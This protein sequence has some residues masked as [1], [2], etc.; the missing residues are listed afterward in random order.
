MSNYFSNLWNAVRGVNVTIDTEEHYE[1]Y[2]LPLILKGGNFDLNNAEKIST[3][4]TCISI[5]ANSVAR[6]PINVIKPQSDGSR[7]PD[8]TDYR[9]PLLHWQPNPY[10]SIHKML[11]TWEWHCNTNG[12]AFGKIWRDGAGRAVKVT[13]IPPSTFIGVKEV[14]GNLYYTFKEANGEKAY[15]AENI[16]HFYN[17]TKDGM[18][19]V[20]PLTAIRLNMTSSWQAYNTINNMYQNE[21]RA[22]KA[23]KWP[24]F[25][26]NKKAQQEA[27]KQFKQEYNGAQAPGI[28]TI[29]DGADLVDLQITP[30]DA[31]FI[32][33]IKFNKT[34]IA[35]AFRVPLTNVGVL[36]AAKFNSV[37]MMAQEFIQLG[38]GDRLKMY[39][40]ELEMKL[41]SMEE[42]MNG[43]SIEFNTN[44]LLQLD[45]KTRIDGYTRLIQNGQMTPNYAN[46]LENLPTYPEGD[47]HFMASNFVFVEDRGKV[48]GADGG[49]TVNKSQGI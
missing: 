48:Q 17:V 22:S 43:T 19:G 5:L 39:R 49:N 23:L 10:T 9:Y 4:Y 44:A 2:T 35:S 38:L 6:C 33:T 1:S 24:Q 29:P 26:P 25:M 37:E 28:V 18:T 7:L 36:E 12:N 13:L 40:T 16:L 21:L 31:Q 20:S 47:K 34:D 30:E 15:N 8:K 41:L 42:K 46:I 27:L 45:Y 32:E 11:Q 14:R 3:V